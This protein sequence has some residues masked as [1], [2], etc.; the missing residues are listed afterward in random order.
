MKT[1]KTIKENDTVILY[2]SKLKKTKLKPNQTDKSSQISHKE[3]INKKYNIKYK[4]HYILKQYPSLFIETTPRQTQILFEADISLII[5]FLNIK[6]GDCVFESGTGS[7]ILT[8]FLSLKVGESGKIITYEKNKERFEALKGTFNENVEIFNG[9][10][11]ECNMELNYFDA[12]F[13]DIPDPWLVIEKCFKMLKNNSKICVF[14][15]T[16]EQVI[17]VKNEMMKYFED[18]KMYENIKREYGRNTSTK[19]INVIGN[20]YSHTGFLLFAN[21]Y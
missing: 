13:L 16:V 5:Y 14:V 11:H 3:L 1:Q 21:K 2:K 4:N 8:H 6:K 19:H 17:K 15:P 9:D 18:L 7:G 10:I 12:L 20:Q